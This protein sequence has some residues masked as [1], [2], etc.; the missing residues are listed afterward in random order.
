MGPTGGS[1]AVELSRLCTIYKSNILDHVYIYIYNVARNVLR[2]FLKYLNE[3]LLQIFYTEQTHSFSHLK[4]EFCRMKANR[5]PPCIK[6][7]YDF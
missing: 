7:T 5:N 2:A 6:S 3:A 4:E 1:H